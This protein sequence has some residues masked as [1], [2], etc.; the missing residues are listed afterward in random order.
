MEIKA[1]MQMGFER[2]DSGDM[3]FLGMVRW[4]SSETEIRSLLAGLPEL[5]GSNAPRE[6]LFLFDFRGVPARLKCYFGGHDPPRELIRAQVGFLDDTLPDG[7]DIDLHFEQVSNVLVEFYGPPTEVVEFEPVNLGD[8]EPLRM[9][10]WRPPGSVITLILAIVRSGDLTPQQIVLIGGEPASGGQDHQRQ[11]IRD[12]MNNDDTG[13]RQ[14]ER[15][16]LELEKL[17]LTRRTG[18]Q[19]RGW[20]VFVAT[21]FAEKLLA[22]EPELLGLILDQDLSPS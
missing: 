8:V 20:D 3:D 12:T 7:L 19:R 1:G 17:G 6:L 18:E 5:R 14:V 9:I 13:P 15:T 2:G 21:P 22:D 16:L 11:R 4:G 10:E